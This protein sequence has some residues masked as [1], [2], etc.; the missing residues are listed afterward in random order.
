VV[1]AHLDLMPGDRPGP[2][3]SLYAD[4]QSGLT[5]L[6]EEIST[7]WQ[8]AIAPDWPR[9]QSLL[10]AEVHRRAHH[11]AETGTAAVLNDLHPAITWTD[12]PTPPTPRTAP[13]ASR[14]APPAFR[15]APTAASR[16]T[17]PA[18]RT[19]PSH[20][21]ARITPDE[22]RTP[23]AYA[24]QGTWD[25]PGPASARARGD[26]SGK[27][28]QLGPTTGQGIADEAHSA[29][30]ARRDTRS[31]PRPAA[32]PDGSGLG[33]WSGGRLE[34]DQPHCVAPD[35]PDAAG[36]IL[37]PSVFVWP[38]V[39]T[40]W[41]GAVPQLAYPARGVATLW[42]RSSRAPDALGAVIG[43]GRARLLTELSTPLSTT[44]LAR[45]TGLSP[46]GVSQHLNALRAAGLIVT[47]RQ[48]RALLSSRTAAANA[49]LTAAGQP[50]A[51][52]RE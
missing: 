30:P 27:P 29:P 28:Q 43:R 50:S 11:L 52:P 8:T 25:K 15:T 33:A 36:L 45:R 24:G 7:F 12:H 49:L 3:R 23:Q 38:S 16:T 5:R 48:G 10:E 21:A 51:P 34:V 41:A 31:K 18:S 17:P 37:V 14:T 22:S 44:E 35:V 42:E 46:G 2:L 13:P 39:M 32:H 47:H 6:A 1:C 4:P 40:V 20:S 26:G 19:A 9:M